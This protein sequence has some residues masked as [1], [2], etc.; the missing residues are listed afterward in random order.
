MGFASA[1]AWVLFA[2]V[3]VLTMIQLQYARRWVHYE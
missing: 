1:I 3:F 2:V